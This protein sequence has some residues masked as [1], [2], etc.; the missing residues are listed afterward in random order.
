[1]SKVLLGKR[2]NTLRIVVVA[3]ILALI[4][5]LAVPQFVGAAPEYLERLLVYG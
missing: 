5:A 3:T 1:M 4:V 2:T